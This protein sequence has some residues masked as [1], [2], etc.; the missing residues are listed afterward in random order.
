[1]E[2]ALNI[3]GFR[4]LQ[5]Y[6]IKEFLLTFS[7]CVITL[8]SLILLGRA[9]HMSDRLLGLSLGFWDIAKLFL[10]MMPSFLLIVFPISC[11][12]SIFLTFLRMIADRELVAVKAGGISLYQ[13]MRAPMFFSFLC[14]LLSL[15]VSLYSI[16]WGMGNFRALIL[17][18]ASS[19][20]NIVIQ[21]GVFN[22]DILKGITLFAREVDPQTKK[23]KQVV[24]EDD[25]R[26]ASDTLTFVAPE[27]SIETD[28]KKGVLVFKLENGRMYHTE[29]DNMSVLQF[30][31]YAFNIDLSDIL[32]GVE[33]GSIKPK[34]M[35]INTLKD[36]IAN[37]PEDASKNLVQRAKVELQKRVS[38][39]FACLVLGV[40]A[41]PIACLFEGVKQQ[42]GVILSFVFFFIYYGLFSFGIGL[43][44]TGT[45][46]PEISL[47]FANV[48]FAVGAALGIY[49]AARETTISLQFVGKFLK[50][51]GFGKGAAS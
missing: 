10:Y 43:G 32:S 39:P 44:E 48:L 18:I 14:L 28:E 47:W 4:L 45:L 2:S 50:K 51:F 22:K 26:D 24:F 25:S 42:M 37:P 21:P 15:Y 6:L 46:A 13:I 20:A 36:V 30:T 5:R 31:E 1:M 34:E 27:G 17:D 7:V 29:K 9:V 11:M 23:L 35:S 40:F 41:M 8:I 38:L 16:A 19:R 3:F 33:L 49:M 12:V